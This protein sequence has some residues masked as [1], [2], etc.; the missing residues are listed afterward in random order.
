M[1]HGKRPHVSRAQGSRSERTRLVVLVPGAVDV[2]AE[3]LSVAWR[4]V[5]HGACLGV[6]GEV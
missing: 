2:L 4:Q 5:L 1:V 6:V 3:R